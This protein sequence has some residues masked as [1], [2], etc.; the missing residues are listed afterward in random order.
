MTDGRELSRLATMA[1]D[2]L[3]GRDREL[4]RLAEQLDRA[5]AG[6]GGIVL[7]AGEAGVGKTRLSE[8]LA[9]AAA[10]PV[11]RG[12]ASHDS[13]PAYGPVVAALRSLLRAA[14][15]ALDD[16][17]PLGEHL[18][19]LLPE[20]GPA[21]AEVDTRTVRE[22]VRCALVTVAGERGAL[23]LLDDL[24]W[25]DAATL[26]LLAEMAP[27]HAE[28]QLL[29]VVAYRSDEVSRDH[30]L[31]RMR[32]ELRRRLDLVEIALEPLEEAGTAALLERALGEAP[33]PPLVRAVHDRSQGL[34]FFVEELASALSSEAQ[35]HSGAA[36]L[37]LAEG[38]DV[39]VP[40]TVRD[41]VL[42]RCGDLGADGR[43]AAEAAAVAGERFELEAVVEL[44]GEAG[45]GELIEVGLVHECGEG[46]GAF[47]HAL[48]REALYGDVP[49]LRRR[50]LHRALGE[51]LEARGAAAVEVAP[52][53]LGAH[54][55][56]RARRALL[57]AA[58]EFE[59]AHA[60]RDAAATARHAL[61]L[62]PAGEEVEE[63]LVALERHGAWAELAGELAD[64]A[65]SWR[66]VS[67]LCGGDD[68]APELAAA[69]RRL[70][71]ICALQGDRAGAIEALSLAADSFAASGDLGAAAA[72][73]LAASDFLQFSGRHTASLELSCRAGEEA[74][75]AART[76]L[77]SRRWRPRA[78]SAPSAAN[79]NAAWTWSRR[80][81]RWRS[82]TT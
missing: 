34:P 9:E 72:D 64:A 8:E 40:E 56:E 60:Y 43:A 63:R 76:D 58:S 53:W 15:G 68:A 39:A 38:S 74:R 33:S 41:A 2:R 24:Q 19:L 21:P 69:Q 29:V 13:T 27:T 55:E 20:L 26:E 22:A 14:P 79:S 62:W 54:D 82:T 5:V 48:V 10:M 42:L 65:R 75:A 12:A 73:R 1:G 37:E 23:V 16:C 4:A 35:L 6:E 25:S 77:R 45:V 51:R 49:W 30:P 67:T 66:E 31:R 57:R 50:E 70:G 3:I 28:T 61:E 18:R 17:G 81:S 78:W 36:G 7:L 59:A 44:A 46:R 52:H 47:R 11:L 80:R 32:G 71:R